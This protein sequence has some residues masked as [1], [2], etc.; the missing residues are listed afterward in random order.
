MF[1]EFAPDSTYPSAVNAFLVQLPGHTI[2]IDAGFGRQLSQNLK[3]LGVTAEQID[4]VA[5]THLHGDHIGGMLRDGK[6]MFPNATVYVSQPEYDYWTSDAAMNGLPENRRGGF[7]GA[8]KV[9]E[10]YKN[11]LQLINVREIG[12]APELLVPGFYGIAAYG[13]TPGHTMFM[14]ESEADKFLVWGDITHATAIQ[15]PYPAVAVT[16][17]T[18]PEQAVDTRQKVL[19]HVTRYNIPV[20]GAHIAYPGMGKILDN[21]N[22]GYLFHPSDLKEKVQQAVREQLKKYSESRL[23][24]IY[25]SFFQDY[26]GPEHLIPDTAMAAKYLRQ[27]L[28]AGIGS[29]SEILEPVGWE[30]RFYRVNLSAVKENKIPYSVLLDAFVRS[31]GDAAKPPLPVWQA[32]WDAI[33]SYIDALQLHIPDYQTDKASLQEILRSGHY[34]VH[35]SDAFN[36]AYNPHYRI[37]SKKI[38]EEELKLYLK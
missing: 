32:Q 3:S 38:V 4:M 19:D 31:A 17:D 16:Y 27:E 33:Q 9:L 2:L 13:H 22:K 36:D 18:D 23:Q 30:G 7:A 26:F 1:R 11:Q 15:M 37:V 6:P 5:L 24:D 35:H 34:A 14:V 10:A 21:R 29:T 25:K 28:E 20:A 12:E 8:R